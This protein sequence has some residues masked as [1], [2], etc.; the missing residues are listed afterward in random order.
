MPSRNPCLGICAHVPS[1]RW[2]S[3]CPRFQNVDMNSSVDWI[4]YLTDVKDLPESH[5]IDNDSDE[6]N[7]TEE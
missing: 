6:E 4:I 5:L 2:F 1:I 3:E 7:I